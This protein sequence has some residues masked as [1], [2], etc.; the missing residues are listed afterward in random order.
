MDTLGDCLN[1]KNVFIGLGVA[2]GAGV[3]YAIGRSEYEKWKG[4]KEEQK[5]P[6]PDLKKYTK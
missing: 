4:M 6:E 3:L 2:G 1:C 5:E